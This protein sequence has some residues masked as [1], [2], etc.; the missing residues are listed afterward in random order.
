MGVPLTS[1]GTGVPFI[2]RLLLS[3]LASLLPLGAVVPQVVVFLAFSGRQSAAALCRV[4]VELVLAFFEFVGCH[5]C[6]QECG[7]FVDLYRRGIFDSLAV[8]YDVC[9]ENFGKL[10]HSGEPELTELLIIVSDTRLDIYLETFWYHNGL[11]AF[12]KELDVTA[13]AIGLVTESLQSYD[14]WPEVV[15]GGDVVF[16]RWLDYHTFGV[17]TINDGTNAISVR[18]EQRVLAFG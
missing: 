6:A 16:A 14:A 1:L 10:F 4:V 12:L 5:I 18:I 11:A 2:P 15:F 13:V 7:F 3:L 17:R 8:G 9:D